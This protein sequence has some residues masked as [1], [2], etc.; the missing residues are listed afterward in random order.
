MF[1][2][3]I[4]TTTVQAQG[5]RVNVV[6]LAMVFTDGFAFMSLKAI[7]RVLARDKSFKSVCT[8]DD[9]IIWSKHVAKVQLK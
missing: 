6:V 9:Y 7:R 8:R 1:V 3:Y 2:I 4:V 5:S